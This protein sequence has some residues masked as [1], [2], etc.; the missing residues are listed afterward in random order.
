MK[1][2]L[3]LSFFPAF[4]P[5]T[6]GGESR[7][8]N[9][10][11]EL[12]RRFR[13]IL[14]SSSHLDVALETIEHSDSFREIRVPKGHAFATAW[15]ELAKGAGAGD[16]SAPSLALSSSNFDSLHK[17]Y[18]DQYPVVD[19]IIH[20]SPFLIDYD[21]FLGWDNKPRIYNAYNVEYD[22]Y[23][24]IHID[25]NG[26]IPR[27]VKKYEEKTLRRIKNVFTCSKEDSVRFAE[28][29]PFNNKFLIAP[30]GISAFRLDETSDVSRK[31]LVFMG[32]G[33]LPNVQAAEA[34]VQSIAPLIEGQ[35][36]DIIGDCLKPG[37][38]GAN[39]VAHG[40]LSDAERDAMLGNA[41]FAIN[42][43]TMGGGSS[44]KI[45][46]FA[47][48]G[49]PM[50]STVLGV[51]GFNFVADTHFFPLDLNNVR[52][53]VQ[54]AI[55]S[56]LQARRVADAARRHI[57]DNFTWD[58][59][60]LQNGDAIDQI[61]AEAADC[62]TYVILNDYDPY[63]SIGGGATRLREFCRAVSETANVLLMC[64]T[65]GDRINCARKDR[66]TILCIPKER[67]HI[68]YENR[69]AAE[70][71]ISVADIVASEEVEHNQAM[72]A[73]YDA[74]RTSADLIICEHPYMVALPRGTG[75]KF[76]YSSQ[77]FEVGL[78]R[79]MLQ[80]H[81]SRDALLSSLARTESYAVACSA[82]TVAVSE[83]DAAMFG[84]AYPISAP[85]VTIPNGASE[86]APYD[87]DEHAD[88]TKAIGPRAVLFLGSGHIPNVE[89]AQYIVDTLVPLLGDVEFHFVGSVCQSFTNV[90]V[91]NLRLWGVVDEA[92]KAA[93]CAQC[94]LAINPMLSGSGSNVK[95]ADY[96]KNGLHVISTSFGSRGYDDQGDYDLTLC[97]LDDLGKKVLELLVD[98]RTAL[99]A[100]TE[101][102]NRLVGKL[103]MFANATVYAGLLKDLLKKRPKALYVTYRYNY[104]RRGGGEVYVNRLIEGLAAQGYDVDVVS[105][106]VTDIHDH[107]RFN[108]QY[109]LG[110]GMG[111]IPVGQ[112]RV[113]TARFPVD[114]PADDRAGV[115]TIWSAQPRY[116]RELARA[117]PGIPTNSM[118]GWGWGDAEGTGRWTYRRF[119]FYLHNAATVTLTGMV[120][121]AQN[122]YIW[123]EGDGVLLDREV[124]HHFSITF[125]ATQGWVEAEVFCCGICSVDD[126]RSLGILVSS[127]KADDQELAYQ[128]PLGPLLNEV[129]PTALF[130]AHYTAYS[131]SRHNK[132]ISL[133]NVRGPHSASMTDYI[134]SNARNYDLLITHNVVFKT[135]TESI[136][137]AKECGVPS[138]LIPHTHM[139]D[140]Y[141]HFDD[142]YESY[143]NA[144]SILVSPRC[145]VD[146]LKDLGVSGVNYHAPG[147][148][149]TEK[150]SEADLA[151]FRTIYPDTTPF[152]LVLGRKAGAK[153]YT[154]VIDACERLPKKFGAKVVMIG[155]DDDKA[156]LASECV[157]YLGAQ[158]RTVVRGALMACTALV[159]MSRSESFG[160]VLLEA[161]LAGTPVLANRYCP[162]FADLVEDDVNGY[163]VAPSALTP[164][165]LQL[166]EQPKLRQR[167]GEG[168]RKHALSHDWSN[169]INDF[170]GHCDALVLD[171]QQSKI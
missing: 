156:P 170:V 55:S 144:D 18:L 109:P 69:M 93:I 138:I 130:S 94:A 57:R 32:S 7:L 6:S 56:G 122:L 129:E 22:L 67:Q 157:I 137:I 164:L 85:I 168:G 147:I 159:S 11:R 86:P 19:V 92:R 128:R 63:D 58:K 21:L 29:Y 12:S 68:E 97:S 150:F 155:P 98:E 162:A 113:R 105:P 2:L 107:L 140:D 34:I 43:L 104:P 41:A 70:F 8:F 143:K 5:P 90:D 59:I 54:S 135:A 161:G 72:V 40:R 115:S 24:A 106:A 47:S 42:P 120:I 87:C 134:R 33:H 99:P 60:A 35:K 153:G 17:A 95:M 49:L 116:E 44:L 160:I 9:V 108:S 114:P 52:Q 166:L 142:I 102:R 81:P 146:F 14:I 124:R 76:V 139:E 15:A 62:P 103:S 75:D 132:K 141:Y 13:V 169:A 36:F 84:A 127:L 73:I 126:V 74:A 48:H 23:S 50:I 151:A 25:G 79:S 133:T 123:N 83:D 171:R 154:D 165:M 96:L 16:L 91:P 20:E 100:R 163:R 31:G 110:Q 46:D 28:L 117:L 10:Y 82:L 71:Y 78:K 111:G 37:K 53:S 30:N 61:L 1:T 3:V 88:L 112:A 89:A 167:L 39:V 121:D 149:T 119:G 125:T 26:D 77:N 118:L 148:D 38:Y 101:R 65:P 80:W 51:R 4:V 145:S 158:D 66:V 152:F 64:F 136:K 45:A 131:K 27:L